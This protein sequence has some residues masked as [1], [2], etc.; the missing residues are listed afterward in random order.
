M[1][2]F[3]FETLINFIAEKRSQRPRSPTAA[4]YGDYHFFLTNGRFALISMLNLRILLTCI[5]CEQSREFEMQSVINYD[6][7]FEK[8]FIDPLSFILEEIHWNVD[9]SYGT[10]TTLEHLFG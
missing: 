3:Y 6:V 5:Q 1:D 8:S 7:M 2:F 10:Q 4:E 9:R